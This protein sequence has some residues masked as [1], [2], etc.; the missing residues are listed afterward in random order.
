MKRIFIKARV[1]M[2]NG[3]VVKRPAS[4]EVSNEE[5]QLCGQAKCE[6]DETLDALRDLDEELYNK[7]RS[8]FTGRGEHRTIRYLGGGKRLYS[9]VDV[10][11]I[12]LFWA[13]EEE[14][15]FEDEE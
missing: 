9:H 3:E 10:E 14:F 4:I 1:R 6:D 15:E 8:A 11:S 13:D 2:D 5:Y 12:H 7:I